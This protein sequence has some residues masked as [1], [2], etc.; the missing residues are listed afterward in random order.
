[1]TVGLF[2][3]TKEA[4]LISRSDGFFAFALPPSRAKQFAG[5][6]AND[7]IGCWLSLYTYHRAADEWRTMHQIVSV[8]DAMRAME[9]AGGGE[10]LYPNVDNASVS[11]ASATSALYALCGAI[12]SLIAPPPPPCVCTWRRQTLMG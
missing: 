7:A 6:N 5:W 11:I 1:M 12:R 4:S 8:T 9:R 2:S 3:D 10:V